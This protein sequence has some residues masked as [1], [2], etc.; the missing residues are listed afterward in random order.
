MT[1]T[2]TT[3]QT[4]T[5]S[6]PPAR[7]Q[8]PSPRGVL[9]RAA[10]TLFSSSSSLNS[11][12]FEREEE[13]EDK[14]DKERLGREQEH[15]LGSC[16]AKTVAFTVE[17]EKEALAIFERWLKRDPLRP[18]KVVDSSS[19]PSSSKA[20][21]GGGAT[22]SKTLIP[23]WKFAD[24]SFRVKY[25]AKVGFSGRGRKDGGGERE[26]NADDD[27]EWKEIEEW[28]EFNGGEAVR[29]DFE[30]DAA[31]R[32]FATFS[33]RPD[34]ARLVEPP[35][36]LGGSGGEKGDVGVEEETRRVQNASDATVLPFEIKRSF[37]WTLALANIRDD[38]REKASK[39]LK[40]TFSTDHVKDVLVHLEVVSRGTP[41]AVYLPAYLVEFTH[42]H[43]T[44]KKETIRYLRRNAIVCG[45]SG[46]VACDELACSK[47]AMGI[48]GVGMSTLTFMLS[49]MTD[50]G[51]SFLSGV[52]S[53]A[54]LSHYA[55]T[56]DF[57]S[58]AQQKKDREDV[59]KE[60]NAFN[61][62][63]EQSIYWLDE[64]AQLARDDAEWSR[65]KRTKREDWVNEE[66]KSWALAIWEN[67]VYRRRERNERREELES[68]RAQ[69]LEA[70]RRA[71][72]KR[73]K[74]GDDWDRASRKA[75][76]RGLSTDS[77]S[78]YKILELDD[79]RNEATIEEIKDSYRRLA[80][81]WHPDKKGGKV[82]KFQMIQKA[83]LT[84]GNKLRRETY[85]QM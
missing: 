2:T 47:R 62:A 56:L 11:P 19:S 70:E 3:I 40:D 32:Q 33:V 63:T 31:A 83:Y 57:R 20:A 8:N 15:V 1:T 61:F 28:R 80:H 66:R 69:K 78:F 23:Y 9:L 24:V 12:R 53:A 41:L 13:E 55:K 49:G 85:D 35:T 76:N 68:Q 42:G 5:T 18:R 25:K 51:L 30:K 37:A 84:L 59:V 6:A 72:E 79:K 46:N 50:Y 4:T 52:V 14:E 82:E 54:L 44:E 48:G 60:H 73:L 17:T 58:R 81:R 65:W 29:Y 36:S 71:E 26:S 10:K 16:R 75:A 21:G 34:F 39:E 22:V 74:W 67:Q 45:T 27:V 7:Y 64:C 77:Q 38:L 43:E